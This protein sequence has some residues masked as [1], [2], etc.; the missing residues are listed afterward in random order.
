[1]SILL[2]YTSSINRYCKEITTA[3][4]DIPCPCCKRRLRR[5][6]CTSQTRDVVT[7]GK[8]YRIPIIRL[9]CP[10]CDKT[11]SLLPSFVSRYNPYANYI[12]ECIGRWILSG[13]SLTQILQCLCAIQDIP[14]VSLRSLYRWKR[15]WLLRFEPWYVKSRIRVAKD[16]E[17][18]RVLL[19]L[20]RSNMDARLELDL[21]FTY[22]LGADGHSR[23]RVGK[24]LDRL[25]L[26]APPD[27]RW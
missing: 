16:L 27:E 4:L 21:V 10:K 8:V 7:K 20:Y 19:D 3:P 23:P 17:S 9:R 26:L 2:E 24:W 5:H 6:T 15:R 25:N 13:I 1:M 11:Y 22:S 14:I 12:R 18:S